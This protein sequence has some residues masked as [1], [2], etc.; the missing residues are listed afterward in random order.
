MSRLRLLAVLALLSTT[1]LGSRCDE[2]EAVPLE[3]LQRDVP[4]AF[5]YALYCD[6][7]GTLVGHRSAVLLVH[8]AE[9]LERV[10]ADAQAGDTRAEALFRQLEETLLLTGRDLASE[11]SG[12]TCS[13]L[14]ACVVQW[15]KLDEFMPSHGAGGLRLRQV[16]ADGFAR[17]A[18]V[19]HVRNV[20]TSAVLDVLLVGTVIKAG[21]AQAAEA[22]AAAAEATPGPVQAGS[23]ALAGVEASLAVE[24]LP[25]LEA[26]MAEAEALE[27]GARHPPRLEVLANY[28]PSSTRPP[29]GVEAD[30]PRWTS[31]V[32]YWSRRYEE[33]SGTRPLPAGRA[34]VKPPL[35]WEAYSPFL[36]RFQR[37]L[38]FQRNAT[39]VLQ[40]ARTSGGNPAWLPDMKRP[41]V[42][43]N[44]GLKPE[45]SNTV[46]YADALVLDEASLGSGMR[47]SVHSF[48]M[49]QRDFSAMSD[50]EAY[51]QSRIDAREA[52]TKYGGTVEVRRPG[53]P[54]FQK[55]VVVTR[56]H[57][58]Y[59]GTSLSPTLKNALSRGAHSYE[60]E[61][62]FHVP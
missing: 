16:M 58:V 7:H 38:E 24:E 6:A 13:S 40:Q 48:S 4:P 56:V 33:L 45:G 22:G 10:Y 61:V 20:V 46:T 36:G 18:K 55:K 1:L 19:Q 31:Y 37:S 2:H 53:H 57:L 26:R 27:A 30:S 62:H 29:S 15:H 44:T 32:A 23:I 49:K 25:A 12:I 54:L 14:P 39:R 8:R 3:E 5:D 42:T 9:H 51:N 50:K 21:V 34:E 11:A 35:T 47:P 43:E 17:G 52:K 41:W 60:V 59:D 28:R